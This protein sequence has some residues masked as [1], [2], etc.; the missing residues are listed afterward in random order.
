MNRARGCPA[1]MAFLRFCW[2]NTFSNWEE[3]IWVLEFFAA[4]ES[5]TGQG[6]VPSIFSC[7]DDSTDSLGE[8]SRMRLELVSCVKLSVVKNSTSYPPLREHEALSLRGVL[9]FL[10]FNLQ[11]GLDLVEVVSNCQFKYING[12]FSSNFSFCQCFPS[13]FTVLFSVSC[14]EPRGIGAPQLSLPGRGS[15]ISEESFFTHI[16]SSHQFSTAFP[17]SASPSSRYRIIYS[18]VK[19]PCYIF[20]HV[21]KYT[22]AHL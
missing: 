7:Y 20:T 21:W 8:H 22:G 9:F 1:Q 14:Y 12:Q 16:S 5:G 2:A 18:F 15:L 3:Q 10:F 4:L 11:L 6:W 17:I 13:S 19:W